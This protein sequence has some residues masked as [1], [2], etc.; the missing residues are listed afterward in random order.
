MAGLV[1][2]AP[3]A[4]FVPS[5]WGGLVGPGSEIV[6]SNLTAPLGES[7]GNPLSDPSY[8]TLV[9]LAAY[10]FGPAPGVFHGASYP[11]AQNLDGLY[12]P[13]STLVLIHPAGPRLERTGP[14]GSAPWVSRAPCWRKRR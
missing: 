12:S 3:V 10:D 9:R 13:L 8:L 6:N 1:M 2:T 14:T 5:A 4:D 7:S 11:L